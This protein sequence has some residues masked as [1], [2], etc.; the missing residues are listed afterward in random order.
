MVLVSTENEDDVDNVLLVFSGIIFDILELPIK[1]KFQIMACQERR[2]FSNTSVGDLWAMLPLPR[3]HAVTGNS[4]TLVQVDIAY[5]KH[6]W[7]S[8]PHSWV[9]YGP[10]TIRDS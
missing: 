3:R 4:R 10:M 5:F 2:L 7:P 6:E 9:Y 1:Q 8:L